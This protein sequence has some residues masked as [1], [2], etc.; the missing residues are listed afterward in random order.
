M[1]GNATSHVQQT[2]TLWHTLL[3]DQLSRVESFY[4]ETAKYC[5]QSLGQARTA[6]DETTKVYQAWVD[7]AVMLSRD[8]QR[9]SIEG[10]RKS[11]E[12]FRPLT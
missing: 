4:T 10:A 1:T 12:L 3:N 2:T 9:L 8:L 6:A 5:D 7:S 11:L